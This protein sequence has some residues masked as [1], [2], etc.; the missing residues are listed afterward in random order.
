MD[1]TW[2][3]KREAVKNTIK[4]WKWLARYPKMSKENYFDRH[5][6]FSVQNN[7]CFLCTIWFKQDFYDDLVCKECPLAYGSRCEL[8]KNNIYARWVRAKT[9]NKPKYAK[10]LVKKC[11]KWLEKHKDEKDWDI[12]EEIRENINA[13]LDRLKEYLEE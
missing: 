7:F 8:K 4:M 10:Q 9:E 5:P 2:E 11:E 1:Y 12:L 6:E 3:E 13:E